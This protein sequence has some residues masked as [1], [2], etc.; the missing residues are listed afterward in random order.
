[1]HSR[2]ELATARNS[3]S[4]EGKPSLFGSACSQVSSGSDARAM[5]TAR[6]TSSS[7]TSPFSSQSATQG[8]GG[9]GVAVNVTVG[10]AVAVAVFPIVSVG[11]GVAVGELIAVPLAVAVAVTAEVA[12]A[13]GVPSEVQESEASTSTISPALFSGVRFAQVKSDALSRV[14]VVLCREWP[15][16]FNAVGVPIRELLGPE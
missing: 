11:V 10:V 16:P 1:M 12:V 14:L 13:V 8:I 2:I 7:D 6:T 5:L 15:S 4:T 9:P 3:S